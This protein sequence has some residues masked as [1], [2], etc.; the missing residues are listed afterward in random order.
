M[1]VNKKRT[2]RW[3]L[4]GFA[5]VALLTALPLEAAPLPG[6]FEH[7]G[8]YQFEVIV[9][10]DTRAET[11]DSETWPMLP[12]VGYPAQWR[13][14]QD[15]GLQAK[16]AAQYPD[17]QVAVSPSG[18]VTLRHP[19]PSPPDWTAIAGWVTEGDMAAIDEL[20]ELGKGTDTTGL[21]ERDENL[22]D[23]SVADPPID[24]GPILPFE[25]I[26][27]EP[28]TSPL[29]PFES[30]GIANEPS[31]NETP[32]VAVPFAAPESDVTLQP[33]TVTARAIPEPTPFVRVPLDQL[34]AG[35]ARYQRTSEDQL[36]TAV[37]WLQG[38]DSDSRPIMLDADPAQD[39]PVV[40]GF[41][42][43]IPRGDTWRLGLNFW[44][45]TEGRYLPDVFDMPGPPPAPSRVSVIQPQSNELTPPG[46]DLVQSDNWLGN[47]ETNRPMGS[48]PE[49]ATQSIWGSAPLTGVAP[50]AASTPLVRELPG[51][52]E[53]SAWP[54]RHMIHVADTI[55]LTENRL[56]Y[57]DH[58]VIKVLAIWRELSWYELFRRGEAERHAAERAASA[59]PIA[60][61][62]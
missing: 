62:S 61:G 33:V 58:P 9:M 3:S 54:W 49:A 39:Y 29:I 50:D 21:R 27:T 48:P 16:L 30:L 55:P 14:L 4:R 52:P 13:W 32:S 10:V 45:N 41:I 26:D 12:T 35:L 11:L 31:T 28:E 46:A 47:E 57:Y 6:G 37:S 44:A 5:S 2:R 23:L 56:R 51:V 19:H 59:D 18:H 60:E 17:A 42:Q 1:M 20:I 53:R 7:S 40:Q 15:P 24:A 34:E 22:D 38:P 36:V 43:L 25:A 8:W